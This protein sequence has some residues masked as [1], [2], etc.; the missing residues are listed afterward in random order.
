MLIETILGGITGLLGNCIGAYFKYKDAQIQ[1]E[2]TKAKYE[3]DLKMVAAETEAMIMEAK[4]NIAI[5]RAN[6]EGAI[7][8]EDAKAYAISQ[9]EG[10]KSLFGQ[11]WINKMLEVQ[12]WGKYIAIPT[13][14]FIAIMFGFADWLKGI[15]RPGLTLYLTGVST[16]ITFTAYNVLKAQQEVIGTVQAVAIFGDAVNVITYLTISCTTWWFG[17]RR[18]SKRYAEMKGGADRTKIDDEIKI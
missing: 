5:T 2:L 14:V 9:T 11:D 18:L 3:H 7:E 1:V 6:V 17:D 4:A 10:N 16:W 15:L 12:G 13:A 8:L